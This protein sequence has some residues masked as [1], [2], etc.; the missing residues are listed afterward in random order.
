[1]AKAKRK[2]TKRSSSPQPVS[3]YREPKSV[4]IKMAANGYVVSSYGEKG[5]TIEVAK[6]MKEANR[7]AKALLGA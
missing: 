3:E 5:E 4:T 2:T 6:S 1:M 7:I